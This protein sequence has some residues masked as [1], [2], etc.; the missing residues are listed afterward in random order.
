MYCNKLLKTLDSEQ[1]TTIVSLF[2][3]A[4]YAKAI[5]IV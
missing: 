4:M 1:L 3:Q 2:D 5:E